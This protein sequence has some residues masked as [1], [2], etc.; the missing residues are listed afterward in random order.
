MHG[1]SSHHVKAIEVHR[2]R[3]I[4]YG[5]GDFLNDYEGIDG[6]TQFRDDLTM[7]HFPT[8][9]MRSGELQAL[10]M[11]PLLIRNFRLQYPSDS[12]TRW[13]RDTLD[14]ECRHF[15]ARVVQR[16]NNVSL[17]GNESNPNAGSHESAPI[18]PLPSAQA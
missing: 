10:E 1:H 2:G 14:R 8:V 17:T 12:D 5:C 15:G 11:V 16:G 7:M 18:T 3:A 13:L 9:D 6:S 4:F